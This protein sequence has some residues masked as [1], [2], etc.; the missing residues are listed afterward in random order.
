MMDDRAQAQFDGA[1]GSAFGDRPNTP[2]SGRAEPA[3]ET[4]CGSRSGLASAPLRQTKPILAEEA[5][6]LI[7]D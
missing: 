6:A 2:R 5:S 1:E 7:M 4:A 3:V